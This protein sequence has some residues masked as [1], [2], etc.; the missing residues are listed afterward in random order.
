MNSCRP[1]LRVGG[2]VG[3]DWDG[4]ASWKGL[5]ESPGS[6]A[7]GDCGCGLF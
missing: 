1:T 7:Q 2:S 6:R 5:Q 4:F 3:G